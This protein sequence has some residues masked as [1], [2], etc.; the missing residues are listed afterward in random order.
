[1]KVLRSYWII[2]FFW[3]LQGCDPDK[4]EPGNPDN[5][6]PSFDSSPS[7]SSLDAGLLN[8]AS[9]IADAVNFTNAVW[10]HNDHD[11]NLYLLSYEGKLLKKIPFSGTS[12]DWEDM[13]L[14][15]GP[16]ANTNY[17]YIAETGDNQETYPE[18]YIYRFPEPGGSQERIDTY[19]VIPFTYSDGKSYDV[20]T[21]LLDPLTRDLY[22]V[23]KRQITQAH[24]FRLP[25]PQK[26]GEPNKAEL[27]KTI[28]YGLFTSGDISPD[29]KEILLKN[30]AVIY[31]WKI[32]NG[33]TFLSAL[34]RPHDLLPPYTLEPQGEAIAFDRRANGYFTISEKGNDPGPVKLYYYRKTQSSPAE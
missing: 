4:N 11:P 10:V 23:T 14:G 16:V 1:M 28:P 34:D 33:E 29:G 6:L 21:L 7:V 31:Y 27:V 5:Q 32:R 13:A 15:P 9:G 17:I 26:T 19:D 8:G 30:Y 20:E 22:L 25:Y 24:I 2:S 12:R 3:L 18:Y